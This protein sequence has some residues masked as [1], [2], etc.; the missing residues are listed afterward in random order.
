[1]VGSQEVVARW[2]GARSPAVG[3]PAVQATEGMG[4]RAYATGNHVA[5]GTTP[6]LHTAAHEAAHVVQQ[7]AGVQLYGGVG[8]S[9][10][11]YERHADAVAD[12]APGGSAR[13]NR[14]ARRRPGQ[15]ARAP[16][17]VFRRPA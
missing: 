8:R 14:A 6:E 16:G 15:L 17:S 9:G 5:F 12:L 2:A 7:R 1:M 4:A 3:G 10:D 11:A 13:R